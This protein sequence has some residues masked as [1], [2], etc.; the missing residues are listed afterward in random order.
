M[1]P[2]L[3][4]E[5]ERLSR[6]WM[7]HDPGMLRDY[8]VA[9]VEDPRLNVQSVPSRHFLTTALFGNQFQALMAHELQFAAVM[10]WLLKFLP[11]AG[12]AAELR[13]VLHALRRGADNAEGTVL[14]AFLAQSFAALPARVGEIDVPNYLEAVLGGTGAEADADAEDVRPALAPAPEILNTFAGLWQRALANEPER[15]LTVLEPACGSA[16][17]YRALHAAGLA[18]FLDYTGFD[19]CET[20]I[21]NARM[22]F[23]QATFDVANV[24]AIGAPDQAY[25]VCF[26]HDLFEHLSPEGLEQA[27]AELCRVT[28]LSLCVGFFNL[29]EIREP[30]IRPVEEYHWNTLS[31]EQMTELFARHGFTAQVLHIGAYLRHRTGCDETHNANAYTFLLYRTQNQNHAG[32]PAGRIEVP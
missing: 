26:L 4:Q 10:N 31:L 6:S 21:A 3:I 2:A 8:L 13:S 18:R 28:R 15:R 12:D 29:D 11:K 5:S 22:L 32:D 9:D 20:N 24:F 30:I 1:N 27:V 16:N 17:D 7:R 14:P 19:L 25:E 23:P